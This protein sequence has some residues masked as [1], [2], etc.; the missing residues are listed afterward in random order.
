MPPKFNQKRRPYRRFKKSVKP[1]SAPRKVVRRRS[2]RR[3]Q[4]AAPSQG[5]ARSQLLNILTVPNNYTGQIG[6]QV[7]VPISNSTLGVE[8]AYMH[9]GSGTSIPPYTSQSP[10]IMKIIANIIN[11]G[12]QQSIKF[13]QTNYKMN[14]HITNQGNNF[15]MCEAYLCESRYELSVADGLP[16][17]QL[18]Q[19]FAAA[20]I[21]ITHPTNAN[22]GLNTTSLSPFQSPDFVQLYK[23]KKVI[24]KKIVPGGVANFS[25]HDKRSHVIR[26]NRWITFTAGQTYATAAL[27]YYQ[28]QKVQFWLFKFYADQ[29]GNNSVTTTNLMMGSFRVNMLTEYEYE[30]KYIADSQPLTTN[31]N[32]IN[33]I[34]ATGTVNIMNRYTD[35]PIGQT[36]A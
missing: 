25:I 15:L 12:V 10:V 21:D 22:T 31:A 3:L 20:G 1:K 9:V 13:N 14:H 34:S 33:L 6:D 8:C 26:P 11:S 36:T 35:T 7:L 32:A 2:H 19:G 4:R 5:E 30:Y 23:I 28:A 17:N 16:L 29:L 24:K 27:D 18:G